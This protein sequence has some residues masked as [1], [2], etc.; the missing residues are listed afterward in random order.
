MSMNISVYVLVAFWY[1]L[2]FHQ[3]HGVKLMNQLGNILI[4]NY[5]LRCI[6]HCG[7]FKNNKLL[8]LDQNVFWEDALVDTHCLI[9]DHV[10]LFIG[11]WGFAHIEL[12]VVFVSRQ[13]I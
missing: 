2:V 13:I 9:R 5:C 12:V 4:E 7:N 10:C 8:P 3:V 1:T 6:Y 11:L